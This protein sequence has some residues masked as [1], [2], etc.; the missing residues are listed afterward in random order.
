MSGGTFRPIF[1]PILGAALCFL[2]S[3]RPDAAQSN[4]LVA[5]YVARAV[6]VTDEKDAGRIDIYI[7][8]WS[9]DQRRDAL[10]EA[11]KGGPEKLLPTLQ[12]LKYR[13]GVLTMPGVQGAGPRVRSPRPRNLV[14]TRQIETPAGLQIVV[15]ADRHVGLGE[16]ER[17]GVSEDPE[18]TLIDIRI[19]KDGTGIGKAAPAAKVVFNKDKNLVEVA[20]YEKAPVR[21][22]DITT[23]VTTAV[24]ARP[25]VVHKHLTRDH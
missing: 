18:F 10:V 13:D 25:A 11:L 21:L 22:K 9:T 2:V 24:S 3:P 16:Y 15:A 20:D 12:R 7:E 23:E 5:H 4:S 1:A 8:R 19:A 14:F 6:S 17:W